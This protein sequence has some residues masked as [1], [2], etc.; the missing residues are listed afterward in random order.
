MTGPASPL[1]PVSVTG[2][3]VAVLRAQESSR[4]DRLFDD[5]YAATFVRAAALAPRRP[6]GDAA[7]LRL[8]AWIAARTRFLD[9]LLLDACQQQGCR[10]IVILG[11]GLDARAFRLPWPD[12]TRLWELDLGDVRT[13]KESVIAA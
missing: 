1:P 4:H 11:A 3:G 5:P 2:V 7:W 12:Q 10:Q 8:G 9:D 13:F 6:M